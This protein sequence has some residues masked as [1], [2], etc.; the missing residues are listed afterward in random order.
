[1]KKEKRRR[2]GEKQKGR[3][4]AVNAGKQKQPHTDKIKKG[5]ELEQHEVEN[6]E[7]GKNKLKAV[8]KVTAQ[9]EREEER[10]KKKRKGKMGN[11][12]LK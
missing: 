4:T 8:V 3:T 5:I 11:K 9:L 7:A 12:C 1:M 10:E 6:T 2:I